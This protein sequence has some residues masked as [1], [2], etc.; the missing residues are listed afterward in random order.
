[1][2]AMPLGTHDQ[3]V[4]LIREAQRSPQE[5]VYFVPNPGNAG[6]ALITAAAYQVF[7]KGGFRVRPVHLNRFDAQDKLVVYNGG[8]NLINEGTHS[9][10]TIRALHRQAR[11]LILLPHTVTSVDPLLDEL[12]S[13]VTIV[14]REAVT[15]DY[16]RSRR[17]QHRTLLMHDLVFELDV[18]AL[19]ARN[20]SAVPYWLPLHFAVNKA[21][22]LYPHCSLSTLPRALLR[23]GLPG[24]ASQ[25]IA[26]YFRTDGESRGTPVPAD[27]VDISEYFML[28]RAPRALVDLSAQR[29]IRAITGRDRIRTDRLHVTIAA[30]ILGKPVE[31]FPNNYFKCAAVFAHSIRDRYPSVK[32]MGDVPAA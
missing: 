13:N 19:L 1:M 12:G 14:A 31:F 4:T 29:F 24:D 23:R 18:A 27:N 25:S 28:E 26:N 9:Y 10:R 30:A 22:S 15:Y 3:L 17:G 6:D 20:T 7:D 21:L 32:W 11:R 16:L 2:T 8:G 5:Q